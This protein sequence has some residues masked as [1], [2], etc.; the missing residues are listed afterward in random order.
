MQF[1][2]QKV[3]IRFRPDEADSATIVFEGKHY[4]L[5]LTD[6][7]ENCRTKRNNGPTI[8]YSKIGGYDV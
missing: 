8:D 2:D 1:I 3:E 6:K 7:V 5:R 4:P